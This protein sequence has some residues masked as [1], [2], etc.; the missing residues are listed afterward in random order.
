MGQSP[1][2]SYTASPAD[3]MRAGTHLGVSSPGAECR[4]HHDAGRDVRGFA[5]DVLRSPLANKYRQKVQLILTSP[6]F[7]LNRKK[8][9]GNRHRDQEE[10]AAQHPTVEE[11]DSD[12]VE[13]RE[14]QE[15]C[16]MATLAALFAA[17]EVELAAT[18]S[19]ESE[20]QDA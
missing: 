5:E 3:E 20:S 18:S 9:Y 10:A 16:R 6:P 14:R 13:D 19:S 8:K 11:A 15:R 7:P 2:L 17:R 4:V 1:N 12:A